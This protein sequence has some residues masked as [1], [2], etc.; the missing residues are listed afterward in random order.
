[1][2]A[3]PDGSMQQCPPEYRARYET[4]A[5]CAALIESG[6]NGST[7]VLDMAISAA[8]YDEAPATHRRQHGEAAWLTLVP[9][10]RTSESWIQGRHA[11]GAVKAAL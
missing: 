11:G 8:M 10:R 1:M 2:P 6:W 3:S 9:P 5:S 4:A 7:V